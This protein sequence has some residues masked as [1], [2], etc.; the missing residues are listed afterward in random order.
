MRIIAIIDGIIV[1]V[2]KSKEGQDV[3]ISGNE[4][5]REKEIAKNTQGKT[6]RKKGQE[7]IK[8]VNVEGLL[9][10]YGITGSDTLEALFILSAV[11]GI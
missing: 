3:Q 5:R 4:K 11:Q 8:K 10:V 2:F 1:F 6:A 7:R 9:S